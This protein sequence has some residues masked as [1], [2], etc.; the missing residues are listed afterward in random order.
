V[1]QGVVALENEPEP[2]RGQ[3]NTDEVDAEVGVDTSERRLSPPLDSAN[4]W[5]RLWSH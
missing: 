4:F 2:G 3:S 5:S 1:S